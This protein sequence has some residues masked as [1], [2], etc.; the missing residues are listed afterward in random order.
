MKMSSMIFAAA[1]C[2]SWQAHAIYIPGA[3]KSP[4]YYCQNKDLETRIFRET[5]TDISYVTVEKVHADQ[6]VETVLEEEVNELRNKTTTVYASENLMI[7]IKHHPSGFMPGTMFVSKQE[8]AEK[9]NMDCQIVY[10]IMKDSV[11]AM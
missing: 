9:I 1:L 10:S 2:L 6:T 7:K 8:A 5:A 4:V 11:Q 3:S